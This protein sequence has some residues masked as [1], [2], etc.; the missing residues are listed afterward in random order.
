MAELVVNTLTK[1][2]SGGLKTPHGQAFLAYKKLTWGWF[3]GT[4]IVCLKVKTLFD[5]CFI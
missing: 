5:R 4:L 3:F 2:K 1:L